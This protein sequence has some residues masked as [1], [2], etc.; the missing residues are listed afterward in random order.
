MDP[1]Q[2]L[3]I[4]TLVLSTFFLT[5]IG[6]QLFITLRSAQK[7]LS[8]IDKVITGFESA[9]IG[10]EKG[11]TETV[12]FMNGFKTVIKALTILNEQKHGTQQK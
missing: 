5:I 3:L 9:G 4:I 6:I 1:I 7:T 2:I 11:L 8:K 12:G 10:L